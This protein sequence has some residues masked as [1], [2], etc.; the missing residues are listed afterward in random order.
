MFAHIEV[1]QW[2]DLLP[3]FQEVL[4]VEKILIEDLRV[5]IA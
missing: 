4:K 2:I 3:L 1:V 5:K